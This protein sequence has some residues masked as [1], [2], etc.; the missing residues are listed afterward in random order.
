MT[1]AA[2]D[3]VAVQVVEQQRWEYRNRDETRSIL[4]T[5][6]SVTLLSTAYK[7]FEEFP[8]RLDLAG[9][10]VLAESGHDGLGVVQRVGLR[11]VDVVLQHGREFRFYLRP[12]LHGLADEAFSSGRH[13][14][15]IE[16]RGRTAVGGVSG[17]VPT[18]HPAQ[19]SAP[20]PQSCPQ[21][22]PIYLPQASPT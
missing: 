15:H 2:A 16:S 22:Q 14:R 17:T 3:G 20:Y 9:R 19:A 1:L 7:R 13:L 18:L 6:D 12:G 10:T 11:H 5:L 4:V 8:E 21:G